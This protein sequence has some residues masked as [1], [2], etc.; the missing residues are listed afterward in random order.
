M[1]AENSDV[2]DVTLEIKKIEDEDNNDKYVHKHQRST[3]TNK[4][5]FAI[6]IHVKKYLDKKNK[7]QVHP[8]VDQLQHHIFT[9]KEA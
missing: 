7:K 2:E 5:L 9:T 4:T 6:G 1:S 3:T 8:Q